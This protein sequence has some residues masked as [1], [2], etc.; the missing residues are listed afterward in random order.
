MGEKLPKRFEKNFFLSE[1]KQ[2]SWEEL[3]VGE[4]YDTEPFVVTEERIKLYVEGTDDFNPMYCDKN[5]A[6]RSHF[7][8]LIA[9]PTFLVPVAFASLPPD[10]WVKMPGAINP[11][12]ELTFGVPIRPGDTLFTKMKLSDKYLK[13]GKRYAVADI[14]IKNQKDEFVCS[15]KA[16][17][18]L[19]YQGNPE[20]VNK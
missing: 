8:G 13:R 6:E 19:Q 4:E 3:V 2:R 12:Q 9:P 20:M 5:V 10:N 17:L 18:V 16:A 11:G 15:W 14:L 7:K 1:K